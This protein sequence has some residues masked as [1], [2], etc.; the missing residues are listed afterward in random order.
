MRNVILVLCLTIM[1]FPACTQRFGKKTQTEEVPVKTSYIVAPKDIDAEYEVVGQVRLSSE[2]AANMGDF[3][4]RM[5]N[6]CAKMGGD[7]IINVQAGDQSQ[8]TSRV[9]SLPMRSS[10]N[11]RATVDPDI[12]Y[13]WG[14]GTV[15]RLKD[16]QQRKA[17]FEEMEEGDIEGACAIIGVPPAR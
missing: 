15:I 8:D 17:Y 9:H 11:P 6:E 7:M 4:Q 2:K 3:Y 10:D 14:T 16:E 12:T 1:L 13:T 5:G